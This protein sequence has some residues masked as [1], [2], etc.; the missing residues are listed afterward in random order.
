MK[1][2]HKRSDVCL[3]VVA[4]LALIA[5]TACTGRKEETPPATK[6][7]ASSSAADAPIPAT[8]SPLDVLPEGVRRVMDKPFTADLDEMVKRRVIR[9]AVTFN[10][11]HYFVDQ[12]QERG[13]TYEALKSFETDLNTELKT[14]NLKVSV[15]MIPM[16][17]DQ[18]YPSLAS[19]KVD[20]VAAMIT[21]R[22]ELEKLV[23]FSEPT[24]TNVS[25]VVVTGPGAPAISTVDDLAGKEVF[26]RKGSAY[27]ES[28]TGLNEQL[29]TRGKPPVVIDEAPNA[30]EDDDIL[31]MVN[32][33]LAPITIVDN[34]LAEFWKQVFTKLNVHGDVS[35]RSGGQLAVAFRKKIPGS[36]KRSTS[37]SGSTERATASEIRSSGGISKMSSTCKTP[38][39]KPSVRS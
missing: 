19:G 1:T 18:L 33:G 4:V 30:L 29:K 21:V 3:G 13:I 17:R 9:V 6:A 7:A 20:M 26:V 16:S 23:A 15:A 12:G 37:G 10:R 8:A 14:G 5:T 11:T 39:P 34:Y 35:V 24:R 22:P 38:Q 36:E 2:L 25:Q 27:H 32:A 31:E 28:L